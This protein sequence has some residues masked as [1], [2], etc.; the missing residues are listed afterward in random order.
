MRRRRSLF[1]TND[2]WLGIRAFARFHGGVAGIL[3]RKDPVALFAAVIH[4]VDVGGRGMGPDGRQ[5]RDRW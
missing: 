3:S 1:V 2:P 4:L 5:A